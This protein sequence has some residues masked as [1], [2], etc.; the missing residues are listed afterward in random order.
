M[1]F[2][3]VVQSSV[4]S[5]TNVII[6]YATLCASS[7]ECM[8]CAALTTSTIACYRRCCA[9]DLAA[10]ERKRDAHSSQSEIIYT[11]QLLIKCIRSIFSV[12]S[13][14][15]VLSL[16]SKFGRCSDVSLSLRAFHSRFLLFLKP[17]FKYGFLKRSFVFCNTTKVEI[18]C[19]KS[20]NWWFIDWKFWRIDF[21]FI[22]FC[23]LSLFRFNEIVWRDFK[24]SIQWFWAQSFRRF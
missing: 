14:L 6:V 18:Y 16:Q 23:S 5:R 22:I 2:Y 15:Y 10:N 8:R 20:H 21:I 13:L 1:F 19:A 12:F 7:V 24:T 11:F 4:E 9:V 17:I 3:S